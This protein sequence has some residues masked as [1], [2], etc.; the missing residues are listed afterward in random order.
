M[1]TIGPEWTK[2]RLAL[3]LIGRNS[4]LIECSV[5]DVER[6]VEAFA[7]IY[8]ESITEISGSD[9]KNVSGDVLFRNM[10]FE[11]GKKDRHID[12]V[13]QTKMNL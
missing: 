8:T 12:D 6:L 9:G 11:L 13:T 10:L 4:D 7:E 1:I 5:V 2:R 3:E